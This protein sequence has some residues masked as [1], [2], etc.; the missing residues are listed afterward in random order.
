MSKALNTKSR[1]CR[2]VSVVFHL[3][4]TVYVLLP[5]VCWLLPTAPCRGQ[6]QVENPPAQTDE[7]QSVLA[8]D[9]APELLDA[10]LSSPN[11]EAR[12]ALYRAA[13]AAGPAIVPELEAALKDDRTAEFAAQS[14]AFMGGAQALEI[15]S[16]LVSDKRDLDLRRFYYG[17]LGE[18]DAPRA[19]EVLVDAIRRADQEPDRTVT[20][21]A[22]LALTVRSDASLVAPLRQ[23][24]AGIKDFV[25]HDDLDNA[26][27]VIQIRAR[28]LSTLD[29]KNSGASIERAVRAYF[30]PALEPPTPPAAAGAA[31]AA[32]SVA[33]PTPRAV[34]A[35]T[36]ASSRPPATRVKS[37]AAPAATAPAGIKVEIRNLTF[38][39][40]K[41]RALARV[42]FE[43]PEAYANYDIVLEK[44]LGSWT[45]ASVW[46]GA[47]AEKA[48]A[49]PDARPPQ[50]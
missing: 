47:E 35:R 46:L 3:P 21:A 22:V 16:K 12:D 39:P 34:G 14:L 23:A 50:P 26:L 10:I 20:E 40:G 38:S 13:F 24:E 28:Y 43:D 17:A 45:I 9:W 29:G 44:R 36:L 4:F 41:Q 27:E 5:A 30:I 31:T 19:T 32:S 8:T 11:E 42:V 49:K 7:A 18:F 25:I 2:P 6:S 37:S 15:L 48:P 1:S 33:N